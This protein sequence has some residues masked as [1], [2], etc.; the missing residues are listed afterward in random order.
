[1]DDRVSEVT[2]IADALAR[3]AAEVPDAAHL[4]MPDGEMTFGQTFERA[5]RAAA[6]LKAAGL[7][8][9]ER[10]AVIAGNEMASALAL[11]ACALGGFVAVPVNP[12]L[13]GPVLEY[14]LADCA[15]ALIICADTADCQRAEIDATR[16]QVLTTH[17]F[18]AATNVSGPGYIAP[19]VAPELP[20]SIMYTS[21]T[22][23]RSKGAVLPN[24]LYVKQA[25]SYLEVVGV[26]AEDRFF[27]SLPLFHTN[28]QCLTLMGS[29]LAR[30]PCRIV[31]KF[32]ASGLVR[33]C[34]AF[35]ATVTNLLGAMIP[36]LLARIPS[37]QSGSTLRVIV[38]GGARQQQTAELERRLNVK[39]HQIYGLTEIGICVGERP[40]NV[41][42][43]TAGVPMSGFSVRIADPIDGI[44]EIQV[45]ADRPEYVFTGYWN[46]S[47]A[48]C[49]SRTSD[50]WFLTG[51]RGAI[52]DKGR[53]IFHGR[54]KD[55]IRRRGENVPCED[56]EAVA[57]RSPAVA[58]CAAVAV[59]SE[60][61]EDEIKLAYVPSDESVRPADV[62]A[63]CLRTLPAFM[64][65]RYYERVATIPRTPTFKVQRYRL[66]SLDPRNVEDFGEPR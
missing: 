3:A 13:R 28:A 23:G 34:S 59:E 24:G 30:V 46:N 33:E 42:G 62:Y 55:V 21:G 40:D 6:A 64:V 11:F 8:V 57:L 4:S 63:F 35:S 66:A 22:T 31:N 7:T 38:G 36:M 45:H 41:D 51:D 18:L 12:A 56:L 16:A 32:S 44:G 15:P 65:P 20:V 1:M 27:T 19:G 52:D 54:T 2:T 10:V 9:G 14:L 5:G 50:G 58:D 39:F 29:L 53:L 43:A 17:E 26:R 60:L 49:A 61:A 48:T 25:T 37:S 47:D